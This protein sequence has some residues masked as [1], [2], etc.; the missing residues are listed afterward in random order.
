[1]R[2]TLCIAAAIVIGLTSSLGILGCSRASGD[3]GSAVQRLADRE[4]IEAVLKRANTGFELSDA[5]LFA[6]AF[7]EDAQ[8]ELAGKGPVFGYQKML[9][10]GRADIR[11]IVTDRLERTRNTDPATLKYDP[12]S[13]RRYN[14]NSDSHIEV[15]DAGRARHSSTW[16]VVMKTNVDIH[17]SAVG[18]YEDELVKRDGQWLIHTRRRIE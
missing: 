5:D 11:T 2:T 8:Y 14:R 10:K 17:I 18:R 13:L 1:M 16:M 6:G 4:A 7:A 15:L 9:Y 12:A 3:A